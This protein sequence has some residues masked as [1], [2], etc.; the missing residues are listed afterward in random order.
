MAEAK[1]CDFTG[2]VID[3]SAS[4]L[5]D[6]ISAYGS[7]SNSIRNPFT[8]QLSWSEEEKPHR[9]VTSR[10]SGLKSQSLSY[11]SLSAICENK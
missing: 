9:E 8:P 5:F 10:D 6:G 4:A 3:N 2:L 7:L 1:L 11:S